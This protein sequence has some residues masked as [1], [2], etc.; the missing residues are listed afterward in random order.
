MAIEFIAS[1]PPIQ[2]AISL[3]G[4]ENGARVKLDIPEQYRLQ[5]MQLSALSGVAFK[6]TMK[7]HGRIC[8]VSTY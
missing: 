8:E 7:Q 1:L 4:D 5:V 2:S 3:S 6:V